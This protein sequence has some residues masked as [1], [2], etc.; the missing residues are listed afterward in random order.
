M[1]FMPP[2]GPQGPQQPPTAPPPQMTPPQPMSQQGVSSFAVD[3]GGIRGCLF[4]NT[5]IWPRFGNGFWFYPTFV[6]RTSVAGYRWNGRFWAYS[7]ISLRS[8][9]SFTCV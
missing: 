8:I 4:R 2:Q 9:E 1:A 6:G 5:Y 3:P 7:G